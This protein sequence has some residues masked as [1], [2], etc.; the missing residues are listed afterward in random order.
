MCR[1]SKSIAIT[2]FYRSQLGLGN[3]KQARL[4][5][6]PAFV[7]TQI[8]I[9]Y[10]FNLFFRLPSL[11]RGYKDS[12]LSLCRRYG[13]KFIL[14]SIISVNLINLF[15][16]FQRFY[17]IDLAVFYR[18]QPSYQKRHSERD[19]NTHTVCQRTEHNFQLIFGCQQSDQ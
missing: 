11:D 4:F 10:F 1:Y 19:Q 5:V 17:H 14:E 18:N 2:C 8:L 3:K 13:D 12:R 6:L 15:C 9:D 16:A 7:I